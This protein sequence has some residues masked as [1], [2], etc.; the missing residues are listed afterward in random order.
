MLRSQADALAASQAEAKR[1]RDDLARR[2]AVAFR[3]FRLMN[4]AEN[5]AVAE[6]NAAL[7]ETQ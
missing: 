7:K 4:W 2:E 1:L 6:H 3:V 5:K